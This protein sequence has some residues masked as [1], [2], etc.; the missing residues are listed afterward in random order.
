[1]IKL[2]W[3]QVY[4]RLDGILNSHPSKA[5]FYGI[6]RGGAIVAGF[7]SRPVETP[8]EAD[9]IIDDIYDS[10]ATYK[11]WKKFYPGKEFRF[12][13]DKRIDYK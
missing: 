7:T 4:N 8:E 3:E 12:L 10:G 9:V 1:M 6:P 11:K 2:T 5:T 13:V